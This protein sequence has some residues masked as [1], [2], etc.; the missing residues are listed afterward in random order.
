[1]HLN[2][3][4]AIA[5]AN[6]GELASGLALIAA[7]PKTAKGIVTRLEIDYLKKAR[8]TLTAIGEAEVPEAINE[9]TSLEAR[10]TIWNRDGE[11]VATLN[12]H[13]LLSPREPA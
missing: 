7:M 3:I 2:S 10:A 6:L 8:G 11:S 1:N 4:H 12:V 13:W 9:P 5:L